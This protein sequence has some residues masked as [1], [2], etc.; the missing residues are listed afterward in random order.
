MV[1]RDQKNQNSVNLFL[2]NYFN[3]IIVFVVILV[4]LISYFVVIKPKLDTTLA[5]IQAN[6]E[7]QQK[8]YDDQQKKLANLKI[9]S[10]LYNKIPATDLQKF[11]GVLPDTYVQEKLFGELAEIITQNGF[12]LNS[13][14]IAKSDKPETNAA[15]TLSADVGVININ[16]SLSAINYQGFKNLLKLLENNLRLFDITEVNFS[17]GENSASLTLATYYYKK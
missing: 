9:I 10:D 11:N 14:A 12:L 13:I 2:N 5:T 4:L 3:I 7:Q 16:L 17:P 6:N 15:S 1:V 8:L